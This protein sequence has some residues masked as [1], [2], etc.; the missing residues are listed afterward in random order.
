MRSVPRQLDRPHMDK[1]SD[2]QLTVPQAA[3]GK[4]PG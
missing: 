4:H 2:P 1:E 3:W